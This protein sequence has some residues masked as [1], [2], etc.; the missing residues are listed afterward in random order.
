MLLIIIIAKIEEKIYINKQKTS[1]GNL[2]YGPTPYPSTHV[3]LY[4]NIL[5]LTISL[6]KNTTFPLMQEMHKD[7]VYLVQLDE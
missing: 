4:H 5:L 6:L 7:V 2:L 3:P 1:L